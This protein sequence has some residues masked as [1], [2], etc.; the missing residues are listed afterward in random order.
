LGGTGAGGVFELTTFKENDG[1]LPGDYKVTVTYWHA[2]E[3]EKPPATGVDAM[4][5]GQKPP[6]RLK[7]KPKYEIPP[8]FADAKSTPYPTLTVPTSGPV[9]IGIKTKG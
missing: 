9:T 4:K 1:A 8:N 6:A 2:T 3:F 5:M 7:T